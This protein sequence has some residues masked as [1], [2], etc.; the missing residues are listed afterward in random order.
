MVGLGLFGVQ[1]VSRVAGNP[2]VAAVSVL[3]GFML[4]AVVLNSLVPFLDTAYY[5]INPTRFVALNEGLGVI[6]PLVRRFWG[7]IAVAGILVVGWQI[8]A[9]MR[10]GSMSGRNSYGG[11]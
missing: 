6:G 8:V 9:Q 5:A 1:F 4:V 2:I 10:A 7:V 11:M 3:L